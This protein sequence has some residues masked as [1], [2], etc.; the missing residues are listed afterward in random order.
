MEGCKRT[1]L[2]GRYSH[3]W[4]I[5][6]R[7]DNKFGKKK[8]ISFFFF[9]CF[10]FFSLHWKLGCSL[11]TSE[12]LDFR[13]TISQDIT[14]VGASLDSEMLTILSVLAVWYC[15]LAS[16]FGG[17]PVVYSEVCQMFREKSGRHCRRPL[18][19]KSKSFGGKNL[20]VP[21]ISVEDYHP[22]P[23]N[24]KYKDLLYTYASSA[25]LEFWL[26]TGMIIPHFCTVI[27]WS[28]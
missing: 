17:L 28:L 15:V 24:A 25:C 9:F 10:T 26:R 14:V 1:L 5:V 13:W 22:S 16:D 12:L 20:T 23:T 11:F 4:F 27:G 2:T 8:L 21:R 3:L 6:P 19:K 18:I 7:H